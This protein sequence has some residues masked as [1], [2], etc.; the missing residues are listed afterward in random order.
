MALFSALAMLTSFIPA[1]ASENSD[2]NLRVLTFEDKEGDSYWADLIDEPQSGGSLLYGDV[3]NEEDAYTWCDEGNTNLTHTIPYNYYSYNFWGGG[4]AISNYSSSDFETYGDYMSQLTVL[5]TYAEN[6]GLMRTGGGHNGSDNFAVH[7]GYSDDSGFNMTENL[8]TISFSDG[9]ARVIDHMYVNNT[10]YPL[11]CFTF[12]N[13]FTVPIGENDWVK[14][15]ATGYNGENKTTTSEFYT[16]NGRDNIVT[17]W[18]KWDLSGLGAVTSIEFNMAGSNDNGYGFSQA[19]YFAYDDVAVR[20]ERPK[21]EDIN[22]TKVSDNKYSYEFSL[23][24]P[25]G[26]SGKVAVAVYSGSTL[27][28]IL[29]ADAAN[30]TYSGTISTTTAATSYKI[31]AWDSLGKMAPLCNAV[32]GNIN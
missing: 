7:Y 4:H 12:G 25:E 32:W 2:Y 16:V 21:F 10:T 3:Y 1:Q 9:K 8:P 28:G 27:L 11:N 6:D 19:S 22:V 26:D 18:T 20:F 23:N 17:E 24:A 15:T 29:A 31:M 14:I 13:E 5:N 30:K